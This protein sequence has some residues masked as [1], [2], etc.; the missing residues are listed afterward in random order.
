MQGASTLALYTQGLGGDQRE[1]AP[2]PESPRLGGD[3]SER[4]GVEEVGGEG[5][6]PETRAL[7]GDSPL[8]SQPSI[9]VPLKTHFACF[10]CS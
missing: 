1:V 2:R 8:G 4:E 7:R 10:C 3:V 6:I 9:W 5:R